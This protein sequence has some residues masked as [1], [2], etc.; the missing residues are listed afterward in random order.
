MKNLAYM[1]IAFWG[2]VATCEAGFAGWLSQ[3]QRGWAFIES[4]G[5]MK[6]TLTSK[7]L[8]VDCDVSGTRH[9]TKKPTIVNSGIGVRK[10]KWSL[11]GSTIRLSV[12]T[13]VFEKGMSFSCGSI[14]LSKVPSGTYS[15][16]YLNPDGTAHPLGTIKLP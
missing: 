9:I 8:D 14:D 1:L 15:L 12:V 3:E 5:G 6:V 10:V 13:S 7:K 16:E 4:V 2:C 11:A